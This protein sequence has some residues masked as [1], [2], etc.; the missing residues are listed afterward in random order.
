M[1]FTDEPQ[2]RS[3]LHQEDLPDYPVR[4]EKPPSPVRIKPIGAHF[5]VTK[6]LKVW[7]DAQKLIEPN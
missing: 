2:D 3:K 6:S 5:N 1:Y 7:S 4:F